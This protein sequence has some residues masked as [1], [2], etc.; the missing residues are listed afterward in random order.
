[1]QTKQLIDAAIQEQGSPIDP[2]LL[3]RIESSFETSFR[4]VRLHCSPASQAANKAL[5]S[6]AFT[7]DEHICFSPE[8]LKPEIASARADSQSVHSVSFVYLLAHE[9]A[10]V[11]QKRRGKQRVGSTRR[12]PAEEHLEREACMLAIRA[13]RGERVEH[14][15]PDTSPAPRLYGPAGHYYTALWTCLAVG[16]DLDIAQKSAFYTQ[17]PDQVKELDA[18]AAGI[19][20]VESAGELTAPTINPIGKAIAARDIWQEWVVQTGL[21]SLTGESA[22][23]ETQTRTD[24]LRTLKPGT[25]EF[26]L[27]I[28]AYGDSFAHRDLET[29]TYMYSPVLG[30]SVEKAHHID[31]HNPDKIE[32]RRPLYKDYGSQLY[33]LLSAMSARKAWVDADQFS[34]DLDGVSALQGEDKQIIQIGNNIAAIQ[35]KMIAAGV[36]FYPQAVVHPYTP[37]SDKVYGWPLEKYSQV[38]LPPTWAEYRKDHLDLPVDTLDNA[39]IWAKRWAHSALPF[40]HTVKSSIEAFENDFLTVTG[41]NLTPMQFYQT[42]YGDLPH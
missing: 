38:S 8:I 2:C 16:F 27:G 13:L 9:L 31:P 3:P 11:V 1:M 6:L 42:L 10:H 30:H 29:G 32:M 7:V 21:H 39:L 23:S 37:E 18:T 28:H 34:T 12:E 5:G 25:L 17:L 20:M 14:V 22:T 15:T 26:G 4:D 36:I 35:S 19:S 33:K 41:L 24:T 40:A